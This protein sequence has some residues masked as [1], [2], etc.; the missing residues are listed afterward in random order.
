MSNIKLWVTAL[1]LLVANAFIWFAVTPA[2]YGV[3]DKLNSTLAMD[4]P[5][6]EPR[7]VI[8]KLINVGRGDWDLLIIVGNVAVILWALMTHQQEERYTGVIRY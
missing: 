5:E 7:E 8:T 2:F 4:L 1:G 6:G 3:T